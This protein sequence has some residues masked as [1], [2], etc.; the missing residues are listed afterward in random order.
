MD[1]LQDRKADSVNVID[2]LI[3]G[4]SGVPPNGNPPGGAISSSFSF[5]SS[6]DKMR[7]SSLAGC[8]NGGESITMAK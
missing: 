1:L 3:L 4:P 8:T 6:S 7:D 2:L 5:S